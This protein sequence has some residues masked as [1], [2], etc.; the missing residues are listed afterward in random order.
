MRDHP[1]TRSSV[2][3]TCRS[4]GLIVGEALVG[5]STGKAEAAAVADTRQ[6]KR[7]AP[8]IGDR[9]KHQ[10]REATPLRGDHRCRMG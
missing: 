10:T 6:I 4:K 2:D 5:K 1:G 7:E 8:G 3:L 9:R